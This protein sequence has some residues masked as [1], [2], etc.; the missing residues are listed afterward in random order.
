MNKIKCITVFLA[1]AII[2]LQNQSCSTLKELVAL[3]KCQFKMGTLKNPKLAGVKIL[4][5][6]EFSDLTIIDAG[7]V[8]A[9]MIKGKL[10]LE[11]TL[12]IDVRNPNKKMAALNRLD[13]IA[14]IDDVEIVHGT[15][16]KRIEIQPNNGVASIPLIVKT[17]LKQ[18]FKKESRNALLNLGFNLADV[19]EQPTRVTLMVKP[20]IMVGK[21]EM[22]YPGYI[23]V[24]QEFS[25][26]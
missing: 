18:I 19:N 15:M 17:D 25:S 2:T 3:S 20:T 9:A 23:S 13:W 22:R 24:K 4:E 7:R 8:T 6:K 1:L 10:P 12:N 5:K 26:K 16:D 14:Y 11:F 21:K